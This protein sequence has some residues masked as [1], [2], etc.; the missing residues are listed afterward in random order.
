MKVSVSVTDFPLIV[1]PEHT[2]AALKNIGADGVEIVTGIK[3]RWNFKRIKD[4]SDKYLLPVTSVHQ[5]P[6]SIAGFWFDEGFVAEAHKI[7]VNDFVFH[8]IPGYSFTDK[9]MQRFLEKLSG[10]QDKYGINVLLE[11][12]PWAVRPPLFRKLLPY[13]PDTIDPE[14]IAEAAEAFGLGVTFDTSHYFSEDPQNQ[15]W[16]S[17]AYPAIRNIHLS[18]FEEGRDHLPLDMGVFNTPA[19]IK[20]LKR[21]Q[22]R[23]LVTLEIYYPVKMSF[24]N[25]D[26]DAIKRSIQLVKNS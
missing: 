20:E 5:P 18:S 19:F 9:P 25:Y 21:R 16:F 1:T 13:H 2:F 26:I 17:K 12:M 7:G 10:L 11:N 6:W 22:Y 4:L 8:P 14:R 3:S 15:K 24:R 23:D